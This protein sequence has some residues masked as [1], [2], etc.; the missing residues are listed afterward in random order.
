M[1]NEEERM[2]IDQA[3]NGD[4]HAF[5]TI[6]YAY[7][8]P[9]YNYALR[10]MGNPEDASDAVQETFLK[11]YTGLSAFR[12]ESRL[13]TWLFRI[14]NN[15]CVDQLRARRET[16]S[17]TAAAED[18]EPVDMD[19]PDERFNP[20]R[21]V[22]QKELRENV[23]AAVDR[24]PED[25]RAPLLLREFGGQSYAEIAETMA[26]DPGTVKTRIH[27]AR[28]KLCALLAGYGNFSGTVPSKT[29]EGGERA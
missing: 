25:F 21:L 23:R 12:G 6:V 13:S 1:A 2:L 18:G 24:L 27:R 15:A 17:L 16:V 29:T 22:Q 14:L 4:R 11:A 10:M 5:E 8:R 20:A 26:L 9:L 7:E 28:K 3:R 19:L